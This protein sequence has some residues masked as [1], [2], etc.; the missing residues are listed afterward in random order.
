M[1]YNLIDNDISEFNINGCNIY[2][3]EVC[4]IMQGE[5]MHYDT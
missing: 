2:L 1:N 5:C 4:G 3:N